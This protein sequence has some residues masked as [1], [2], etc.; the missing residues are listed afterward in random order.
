MRI[1]RV[2]SVTLLG[3]ACVL[4]VQAAWLPLKAQLAQNLLERAWN[5]TLAGEPRPRPWPW[6][7]TSP[8]GVL[9]APAQSQRL[10]ILEGA[11]GR[12]L[13]FGPAALG[14]LDQPD[15]LISGHRDTHF[16]FLEDLTLGDPLIV[17]S[18][19]D[20][21]AY[22]VEHMEVVDSRLARMVVE[23]GIDRL[24]LVTCY[25]FD[26]IAP[27]GPLRWVVTAIPV[28]AQPEEPLPRPMPAMGT[29]KSPPGGGPFHTSR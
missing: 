4:G 19:G 17:R 11:S 29:K 24:T 13:A 28:T 20:L 1:L 15:V 18:P 10:L 2:M 6:A 27:G 16:A 23:T 25:P 3:L 22:R 7:D 26:A 8:V 21:R 12:N 14:P 9:E 5:R